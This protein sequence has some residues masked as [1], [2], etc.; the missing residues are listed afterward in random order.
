MPTLW[1]ALSALQVMVTTDIAARGLD[2]AC[3]DHVIQFD[4][5]SDSISYLH[6]VGRTARLAGRL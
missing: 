2:L 4:V 3:V 5:A 1:H 6:R